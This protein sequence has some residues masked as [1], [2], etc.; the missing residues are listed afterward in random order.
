[1]PERYVRD[2]AALRI[3]DIERERERLLLEGSYR[4]SIVKINISREVERPMP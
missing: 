3:A 2:K 1:M 4:G